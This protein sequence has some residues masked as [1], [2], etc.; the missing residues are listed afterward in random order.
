MAIVIVKQ[1][2]LMVKIKEYLV[3]SN[4]GDWYNTWVVPACNAKEAIEKVWKQEGFDAQNA[5]IRASNRAVGYQATATYR[6]GEFTARSIESLRR[7]YD[8]AVLIL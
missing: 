8:E 4:Q 5:D 2:V 7:T 1:V 3:E 6:K